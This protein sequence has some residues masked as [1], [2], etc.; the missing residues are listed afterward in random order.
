MSQAINEKEKEISEL[1]NLI[2]K[3]VNGSRMNSDLSEVNQYSKKQ[4]ADSNN[5]VV[6][7]EEED[8]SDY[9]GEAE[10]NDPD[11]DDEEEDEEEE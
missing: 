2:A 7:D 11:A 6:D 5:Q 4:N 10:G 8:M 9:Y 1:K 3:D